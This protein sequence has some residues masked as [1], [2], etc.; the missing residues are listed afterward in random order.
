MAT[1]SG[2]TP[3]SFSTNFLL[4]HVSLNRPP[5]KNCEFANH[6]KNKKNTRQKDPLFQIRDSNIFL[7]FKQVTVLKKKNT[8]AQIKFQYYSR[9]YHL[10]EIIFQKNK[11]KK[12]YFSF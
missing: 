9:S 3:F 6:K 1:A 7:G 2:V 10:G 12:H 5:E 4:F 8:A 11:N